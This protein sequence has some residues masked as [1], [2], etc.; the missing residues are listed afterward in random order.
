M[1]IMKFV[2]LV[3]LL[4]LFYF[5]NKKYIN[6][7]F[8]LLPEERYDSIVKKPF[9]SVNGKPVKIKDDLSKLSLFPE[10]KPG[11]VIPNFLNISLKTDNNVAS[12]N[13]DCK[14]GCEFTCLDP[15][16]C[17]INGDFNAIPNNNDRLK[18]EV[19]FN[20]LY[21]ANFKK[22]NK[23]QQWSNIRNIVLNNN[24]NYD[25]DS[26]IEKIIDY[27]KSKIKKKYKKAR[28]DK[29]ELE[30][31]IRQARFSKKFIGNEP[32]RTRRMK[33]LRKRFK[34]KNK[35]IK[36]RIK[37]NHFRD[38]LLGKICDK[39]DSFRFARL[40][41]VLKDSY[42]NDNDEDWIL[43]EDIQYYIDNKIVGNN[44][45]LLD[46]NNWLPF[47]NLDKSKCIQYL[48]SIY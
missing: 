43:K 46:K 10:N 7:S 14:Y 20:I 27:D 16:D 48:K 28:L 37:N 34:D 31:K 11:D 38:K 4:M 33:E 23:K 44:K 30:A 25:E 40:H 45:N 3:I 24:S 5:F 12:I 13:H 41:K 6:E 15:S 21:E 32:K 36:E 9:D 47:L 42:D 2:L 35:K 22:L 17:L 26:K 18:T 1:I 29:N 39:S 19:V 8:S